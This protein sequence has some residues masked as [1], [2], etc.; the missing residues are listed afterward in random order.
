MIGDYIV[1]RRKD[2]NLSRQELADKL[3]ISYNYLN[4]IEINK[5]KISKKL[6][7]KMAKALKVSENEIQ[8]YNTV[9]IGSKNGFGKEKR[10]IEKQIDTINKQLTKLETEKVILEKEKGFLFEK[11]EIITD[12]EL[13]QKEATGNVK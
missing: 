7:P 8:Y 4:L 3:D 2:L 10:I 5:R 9:N 6:V 13:K 11:L 12:T 1:L